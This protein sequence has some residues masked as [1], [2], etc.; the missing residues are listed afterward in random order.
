[1]VL[2]LQVHSTIE[3]VVLPP[4]NTL[5]GISDVYSWLQGLLTVRK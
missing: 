4:S 2:K 1:M 5:N 3:N